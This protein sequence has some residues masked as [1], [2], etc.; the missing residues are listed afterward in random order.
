MYTD[1]ILGKI[2]AQMS[3]IKA[4]LHGEIKLFTKTIPKHR[5]VCT[6]HCVKVGLMQQMKPWSYNVVCVCVLRCEN[7]DYHCGGW[8]GV[9]M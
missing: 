7:D 5:S 9:C 2:I 1:A 6:L 3:N 4:D 8:G